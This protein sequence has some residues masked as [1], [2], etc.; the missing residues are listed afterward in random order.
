MKSPPSGWPGIS[1]AIRPFE[2]L[3]KIFKAP[4]LLTFRIWPGTAAGLRL[5]GTAYRKSERGFR[6]EIIQA[7]RI[8]QKRRQLIQ[9]WVVTLQW[10]EQAKLMRVRALLQ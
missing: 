8:L 3:L 1:R 5:E 7:S 6:F 10:I 4:L 2:S 9:N